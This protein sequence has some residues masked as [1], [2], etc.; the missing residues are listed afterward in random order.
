MDR[1]DDR[2]IA[3]N[4]KREE[5][6]NILLQMAGN[7]AGYCIVYNRWVPEDIM[8]DIEAAKHKLR[9]AADK[10]EASL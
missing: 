3:R 1:F 10:L 7:L 4:R 9:D 5:L 2:E 8:R 6:E